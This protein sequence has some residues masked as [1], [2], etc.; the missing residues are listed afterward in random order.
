MES[1]VLAETI[2]NRGFLGCQQYAKNTEKFTRLV[3]G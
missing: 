1:P 2:E 3:T